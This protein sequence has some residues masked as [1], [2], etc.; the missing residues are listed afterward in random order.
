MDRTMSPQ[1]FAAL[2][3]VYV[4]GG[5]SWQTFFE[6]GQRGGIFSTETTADAE[7]ALL[8]GAPADSEPVA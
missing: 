2:F 8:D 7:Q 6:N 1:D 5:M 4:Q 3:G